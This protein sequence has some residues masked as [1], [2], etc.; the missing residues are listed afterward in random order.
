LHNSKKSEDDE[1]MR[2]V[3]LFTAV[4]NNSI[5][6]HQFLGEMLR[7]AT[8]SPHKYSDFITDKGKVQNG[9][10]R[11]LQIDRA[12]FDRCIDHLA[13]ALFFH[14]YKTKWEYPILTVSPNFYSVISNDEAV[15]HQPTKEIVEVSR[16]FLIQEPIRGDN[17]EVF[18][19]RV[20]YEE[21]E[22]C[23]AFAGIFFDFFEVYSYSSQALAAA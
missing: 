19:Y 17:P 4:A 9:A 13:R 16:A 11:A 1:F 5:A 6:R 10:L 3:I 21:D 8:R 2:A 18:K 20:K 23:Y 22:R 12:R 14:A 7:G 15:P